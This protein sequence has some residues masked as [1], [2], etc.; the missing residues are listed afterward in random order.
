M[1]PDQ[2][3]IRAILSDP[4]DRVARLVYADYLAEQGD[5]REE[6]VRA[7]QPVDPDREE[8][9]LG[10]MEQLD[11]TGALF[12]ATFSQGFVTSAELPARMLIKHGNELFRLGPLI[13]EVLLY[14]VRKVGPAL[15]QSP[16]LRCIDRLDIADWITAEDAAALADSPH[17]DRLQSLGLWLGGKADPDL[18]RAFAS[19]R[20]LPGLSELVLY[21]L[22]GGCAAG[23]GARELARRADQLAD[24]IN[25]GRR[26]AIA[27]VERPFTKRFPLAGDIGYDLYAG[28]LRDGR[29]A[30]AGLFGDWGNSPLELHFARFGA[31]GEFL[32]V[33]H[34]DLTAT[35]VRPPEEEWHHYD[36]AELLEYLE[37]EFGFGLARIEVREFVT[38]PSPGP[39]GQ[40]LGVRH[41]TLPDKHL[42]DPDRHPF[43]RD[44][45][46]AASLVVWAVRGG[47]FDVLW[48]DRFTADLEG[49]ITGH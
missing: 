4:E 47:F 11:K 12:D 23:A 1:T 25:R 44:S 43:S 10:P 22:H 26:R 38:D 7:L 28:T 15:A 45:V 13:R 40:A 21:Q 18:C 46:E 2:S 9:W 27:R 48:W 5:P 30:L 6:F 8:S 36:R 39:H 29:P 16:H 14:K 49:T 34:R 19:P 42:S 3:F 35:L 20:T 33:E 31:D 41:W 32:S 17:L 24:Q 37:K